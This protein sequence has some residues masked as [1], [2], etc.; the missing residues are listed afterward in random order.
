M[1]TTKPQLPGLVRQMASMLA[2]TAVQNRLDAKKLGVLQAQ[3]QAGT[4]L[5]RKQRRALA[6]RRRRGG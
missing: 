1:K 3:Q 4:R 5:N 6:A 2:P